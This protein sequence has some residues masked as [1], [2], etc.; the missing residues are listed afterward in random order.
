MVKRNKGDLLTYRPKDDSYYE[1][2]PEES[3]ENPS[4]VGVP[5]WAVAEA[6]SVNDGLLQEVFEDVPP[7]RYHG[8]ER[9]SRGP[10]DPHRGWFEY[11]PFA[12][13]DLPTALARISTGEITPA[14]FASRFGLLGHAHLFQEHRALG[15]DHTL[16]G[17]DPLEWI[18]AHSN[19][20]ALCIELLGR[21]QEPDGPDEE[22]IRYDIETAK[23]GP[24]SLGKRAP[25][26]A[27]PKKEI[28]LRLDTAAKMKSWITPS[29]EAQQIV[30]QFISENIKGIHRTVM[31]PRPGG[32]M[33]TILSYH[34]MIEVAYWHLANQIDGGGIRKCLECG[35]YFV[36]RDKRQQYCPALPGSTRSRCS[37]RQNVDNFRSRHRG[38]Q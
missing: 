23:T 4:G 32:R 18:E 17:G 11:N 27:L 31:P 22:V 12:R 5:T 7:G 2:Y 16:K 35:R 37:S 3:P 10:L 15:H 38:R 25:I 6:Y 24:Y 14:E 28:L 9:T 26:T 8:E 29:V 20:I 19:T 34:A 33:S 1:S 13:T 21:L 36:S 30:R